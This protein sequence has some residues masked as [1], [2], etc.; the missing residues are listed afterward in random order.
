MLL[1]CVCDTVMSICL[2]KQ[3]IILWAA[4]QRNTGTFHAIVINYSPKPK[5]TQQKL[6]GCE[7][8]VFQWIPLLDCYFMLSTSEGWK[9][10][11]DLRRVWTQNTRCH[12]YI[13]SIFHS[14]R[15]GHCILLLRN[16]QSCRH[17]PLLV[18]IDRSGEIRDGIDRLCR[19]SDYCN[20]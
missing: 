6:F 3:I 10:R 17:K 13:L 18:I 19:V 7:T 8:P 12:N 11:F 4:S 9:A 1:M 14:T 15:V 16:V 2:S 20:V 5:Q